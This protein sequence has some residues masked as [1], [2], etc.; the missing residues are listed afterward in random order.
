MPAPRWCP[1]GRQCP[2]AAAAAPSAGG[3]SSRPSPLRPTISDTGSYQRRRGRNRRGPVAS[4]RLPCCLG[5]APPSCS[6]WAAED[7]AAT[8]TSL[9]GHAGLPDYPRALACGAGRGESLGPLPLGGPFPAAGKGAGAVDGGR[10]DSGSTQSPQ[11]HGP[12]LES[13]ASLEPLLERFALVIVDEAFLPLVPGGEADSLIPLLAESRQI[14]MRIRSL[15]SCSRSPGLADWATRLAARAAEALG[16]LA[17]TPAGE[18]AGG[19]PVGCSGWL[20]DRRWRGNG[21]GA[22][23]AKE[24]PWLGRP[25]FSGLSGPQARASAAN[26]P[27]WCKARGHCW[28]CAN[29]WRAAS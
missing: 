16:R 14:L 10:C 28:R 20:G 17:P 24:G 7:A 3:P 22:V 1:F 15:P 29:G 5:N 26:F 6:T 8:G 19:P 18:R 2:R 11:P 25:A 4:S 9:V 23:V 21:C 12:A 27:A 13:A